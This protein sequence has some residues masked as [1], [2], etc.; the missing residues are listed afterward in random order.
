MEPVNVEFPMSQTNFH[1]LVNENKYKLDTLPL[2]ENREYYVIDMK[3]R[4]NIIKVIYQKLGDE[5]SQDEFVLK[6]LSTGGIINDFGGA[7]WVDVGQSSS[8]SGGKR[9]SKTKKNKKSKTKTKQN[10]KSK[11]TLNKKI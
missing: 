9:K 5:S 6:E 11:K 2:Q 1:S 4:D 8:W 3:N 7:K 10:K